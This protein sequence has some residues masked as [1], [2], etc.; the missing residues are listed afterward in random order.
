M[1]E[2]VAIALG[3]PADYFPEYREGVVVERVKRDPQLRDEVFD[4][5]TSQA[6]GW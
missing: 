4:A 5:L 6:K 1:T 2:A 3:L